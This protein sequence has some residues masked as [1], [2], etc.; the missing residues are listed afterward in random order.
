MI[1]TKSNKNFESILPSI[2]TM[3]QLQRKTHELSPT[4]SNL[5]FSPVH[6]SS[7]GVKRIKRT[8]EGI[9]IPHHAKTKL[10][11]GAGVIEEDHRAAGI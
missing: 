6:E 10:R 2:H 4:W 5:F 9:T 1:S 11:D 8:R 7:A 3:I